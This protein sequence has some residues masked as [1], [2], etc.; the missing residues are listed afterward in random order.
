M[1]DLEVGGL[2]QRLNEALRTGHCK[3]CDALA[4]TGSGRSSL[5]D[6]EE[7]LDLLCQTCQNDLQDFDRQPE[8]AFP[9]FRSATDD[10]AKK[11]MVQEWTER[12]RRRDEF[13][14]QKVLERKSKGDP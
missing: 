8:N 1:Q 9:D 13:I 2:V 4:E 5:I 12:Q 6:G 11:R 10:A 14:K 3:Y 7:H